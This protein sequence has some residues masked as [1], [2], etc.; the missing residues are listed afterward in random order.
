ME[1]L[2]P[3]IKCFPIDEY[4][5][6]YQWLAHSWGRACPLEPT[7]ALT[8]T[9]MGII[10]G[11]RIVMLSIGVYFGEGYCPI[12][13]TGGI[14]CGKSTVAT[15]LQYGTVV[16]EVPSKMTT[17]EETTEGTVY[18]VCTDT[19]A[20][21]ILCNTRTT[22][23]VYDQVLDAF[24]DHDIVNN[25]TENQ[26][27]DRT[28]LGAI[29]FADKSKRNLLNHITHPRIIYIML[30]KILYG[31]YKSSKDLC[32]ADVPLLFESGNQLPWL[33]PIVIVVA[34]SKQKQLDRLLLRNPELSEDNCQNRI[35]SQMPIDKKIQLGNICIMNDGSLDDLVT[36]V[37]QVREEIMNRIYG[38][39]LTLFVLQLIIGASIPCAVGTR[40]YFMKDQP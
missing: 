4:T 35:S 33:F 26:E 27:I 40:L 16:P 36:K 31:L 9:A 21:E 2:L 20:H 15:I 1:L 5:Y 30:K 17:D 22:D 7:Y 24:R 8:P 39:G 6:N 18:L 28:K 25:T 37:E 12:A 29:I 10:F 11:I 13:L 34:C 14:A 19:I 32:V 38:V 3:S 23:S